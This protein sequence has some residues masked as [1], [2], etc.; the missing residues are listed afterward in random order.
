MVFPILKMKKLNVS[1]TFHC[2]KR[3]KKSLQ[4][5]FYFAIGICS[6]SFCRAFHGASFTRKIKMLSFS[7]AEIYPE[8]K[9]FQTGPVS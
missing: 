6:Y 1:A 8:K 9:V 3:N 7:Q 2:I 5:L 4:D